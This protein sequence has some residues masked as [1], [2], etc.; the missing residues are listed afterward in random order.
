L[1][2]NCS[3]GG[4]KRRRK[5]V[6]EPWEVFQNCAFEIEERERRGR[7]KNFGKLKK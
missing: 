5:S 6:L 4:E 2:V 3:P 7:R 1:N